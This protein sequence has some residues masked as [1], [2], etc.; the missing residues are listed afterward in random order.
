MSQ[1]PQ[2]EPPPAR[3]KPTT[4]LIGQLVRFRFRNPDTGFAVVQFAPHGRQR[5]L[6]AVGM[7]AQLTE[8]QRV[9]LK[10]RALF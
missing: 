7:L 6:A 5:P 4:E 2:K 10:S 1:K 9:K 8:G 3:E